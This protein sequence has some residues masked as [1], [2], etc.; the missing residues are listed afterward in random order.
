[1]IQGSDFLSSSLRRAQLLVQIILCQEEVKMAEPAK[2]E[3]KPTETP[4]TK[5]W[6]Y[7][8]TNYIKVKFL[9]GE[10][11]A[12]F[13]TLKYC[14]VT[15][16]AGLYFKM[17]S[18]LTTGTR[19]KWLTH[20]GARFPPKQALTSEDHN[21]NRFISPEEQYPCTEQSSTRKTILATLSSA[22]VAAP[23]PST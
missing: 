1:M 16:S 18:S 7:K 5:G 21:Q 23:R 4:E 10:W 11:R 6:L 22:T 3:K 12:S 15:K 14:R 2:E 20:A 19:L 9:C 17:G 8:W 13:F